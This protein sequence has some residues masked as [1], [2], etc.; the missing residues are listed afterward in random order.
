MI[1]LSV[2][3]P[4]AGLLPVSHGAVTLREVAPGPLTMLAPFR[5]QTAALSDTLERHH[6]LGFPEPGRITRAGDV[7]CAWAGKDQALLMGAAPAAELSTRAAVTDQS[8][9]WAM[10]AL[11]GHGASDVLARLVPVDLRPGAF[12]VG[13]SLRT[14]LGHMTVSLLRTDDNAVA[15]LAFRSMAGTLV[16]ELETA[17]THVAARAIA[18]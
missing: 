9:A 15:V 17:M 14:L 13:S 7:L 18:R 2:K 11:E 3:S 10:V 5:G 6:G 12:P 1:D 16:H 8:D 4:C